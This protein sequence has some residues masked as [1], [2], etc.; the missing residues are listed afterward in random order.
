MKNLT[1]LFSILLIVFLL[2]NCDSPGKK[3]AKES[4]ECLEQAV[5][6]ENTIEKTREAISKCREQL[7]SKYQDK[8]QNDS[9][10]QSDFEEASKD[11]EKTL[12]EKLKKKYGNIIN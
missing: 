6:N 5:D 8:I 9:K 4:M 2:T 12:E 3:A 7:K 11:F 1:A 10:F